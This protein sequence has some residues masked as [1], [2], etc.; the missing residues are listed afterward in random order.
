MMPAKPQMSKWKPAK[1]GNEHISCWQMSLNCYL[2]QM[3]LRRR[4]QKRSS[5]RRPVWCNVTM[6]LLQRL[7]PHHPPPLPARSLRVYLDRLPK[8][9]S[10]VMADRPIHLPLSGRL[11]NPHC[12]WARPPVP[13][14]A[15]LFQQPFKPLRRGKKQKKKNSLRRVLSSLSCARSHG[16]NNSIIP[17]YTR[18][19]EDSESS[20]TVEFITI[21]HRLSPKY[22][23]RYLTPRTW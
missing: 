17:P 16:N 4:E 22:N 3:G 13:A 7:P 8:T 19:A 15:L 23:P 2:W 5:S 9:V 21:F 14:P 6:T 1:L 12:S 18:S 11:M 10:Q 20:V